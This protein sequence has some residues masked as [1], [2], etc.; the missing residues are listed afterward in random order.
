MLLAALD[1]HDLVDATLVPA[2]FKG[3]LEPQ[4]DDLI[5]KARRDD[6]ASHGE[7]VRVV[8]LA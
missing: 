1:F 7:H 2:A 5:G 4:C 8:V 3:G 6:P